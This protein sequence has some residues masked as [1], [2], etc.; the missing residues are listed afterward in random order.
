MVIIAIQLFF[1]N[2]ERYNPTL[3]FA[4]SGSRAKV[5]LRLVSLLSQAEQQK[6]KIHHM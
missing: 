1:Y 6:L 2:C 4:Q 3:L 5:H